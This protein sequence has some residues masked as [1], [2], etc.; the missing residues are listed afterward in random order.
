MLR[1]LHSQD[2]HLLHRM[3]GVV[4]RLL[5]SSECQEDIRLLGGIP[6][7][8]SL[9]RYCVRMVIYVYPRTLLCSRQR[10][11]IDEDEDKE[12]ALK[13]VCCSALTQ[14]VLNDANA[15]LLVQVRVPLWCA[16]RVCPFLLVPPLLY[17]RGMACT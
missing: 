16:M 14:L 11:G 12:I 2:L 17:C 9:L 1:I 6:L 13:A 4:E 10:G 8:L 5:D 15:Q 3:V 7:L